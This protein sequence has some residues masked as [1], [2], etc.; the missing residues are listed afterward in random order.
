MTVKCTK[1]ATWAIHHAWG[2]N[3]DITVGMVLGDSFPKGSN[4]KDWEGFK[5]KLLDAGHADYIEEEV[6]KEEEPKGNEGG[7]NEDDENKEPGTDNE[8]GGGA[9]DAP[10]ATGN[11]PETF[12][13]DKDKEPVVTQDSLKAELEKVA[14]DKMDGLM[15]SEK[16]AKAA[17]EDIGKE[18]YSFDV[19]KRL[20][21]DKMVEAIVG[22]AFPDK[23]EEPKKDE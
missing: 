11:E 5:A 7:G 15:G 3:I 9:P 23:K 2:P 13:D 4:T 21:I 12:D 14:L 17:L 10:D 1:D 16:K 19:D 20:G 6:K 18:R 8:G 22:A